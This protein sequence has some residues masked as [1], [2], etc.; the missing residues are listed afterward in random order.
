MYYKSDFTLSLLEFTA[1]KVTQNSQR[2]TACQNFILCRELL[3]EI[4]VENKRIY[5]RTTVTN[6]K[7]K[8]KRGLLHVVAS[9]AVNG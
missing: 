9:R 6:I 4:D 5:F 8:I 7:I 3:R 1:C 2:L